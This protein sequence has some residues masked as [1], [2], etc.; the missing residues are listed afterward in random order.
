MKKQQEI[1]SFFKTL[2][3]L[4]PKRQLSFKKILEG[5]K[6]ELYGFP[7]VDIYTPDNLKHYCRDFSP[8]KKK[9]QIIQEE[10]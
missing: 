6:K 7:I 5:I 8:L 2:R 3:R 9:T 4:Q 1:A 10:V